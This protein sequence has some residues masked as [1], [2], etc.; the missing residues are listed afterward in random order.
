M[1][2]IKEDKICGICKYNR[3]FSAYPKDSMIKVRYIGINLNYYDNIKI[4]D[5][6]Q[7][8][9]MLFKNELIIIYPK[10]YKDEEKEKIE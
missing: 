6:K 3:E 5:Y 4:L 8:N 10:F 2:Y 9:K 1:C 7:Q